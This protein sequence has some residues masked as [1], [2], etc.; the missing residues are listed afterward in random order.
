MSHSDDITEVIGAFF[1]TSIDIDVSTFCTFRR[2]M[3]RIIN[4]GL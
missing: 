3:R 1:E 2:A 4:Y